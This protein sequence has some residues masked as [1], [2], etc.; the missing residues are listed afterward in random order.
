MLNEKLKTSVGLKIIIIGILIVLLMIPS[1][2]IMT[3]IDDREGYRQEVLSDI[4]SKWGGNQYVAG[5]V[6]I[7]PVEF[8]NENTLGQKFISTKNIFLLSESLEVESNLQPEIRYRGIYE[9]LLYQSGMNLKGKF[10]LDAIEELDL[11]HGKIRYDKAYLEIGISDLKGLTNNLKVNWNG[12]EIPARTGLKEKSSVSKG[13]HFLIPLQK[14]KKEYVYSMN[15]NLN[16]SVQIRFSPTG[17]NTIVKISAPWT[18]PSFCGDFLP[19]QKLIDD[20][21]FEAEWE[22]FN[23]NRNFSHISFGTPNNI[24][25]NFFGVNLFYP[26]DQYQQT[27]RSVKYA[28]LFLSLTFVCFFLIEILSKKQIHPLQYLLVGSGIVLFYLLLLSLTEHM[29]FSIAYLIACISMIALI[30]LYTKSA[31]GE[32]KLT[33]IVSAVLLA[34]YGFLFINLQLQDYALLVGSLGLFITLAGVMFFTRKID[35]F[36]ALNQKE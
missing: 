8:L 17:K 35:W 33:L 19:Q 13:L 16:G 25:D 3:I 9:I 15:M 27:T 26:V 31:L 20:Q 23:L 29:A 18:H 24:E 32:F 14:D 30:A 36:A 1:V 28:F 7:I 6:L 10:N 21:H 11:M 22:I 12:Q 2:W 5:P 34:L 4:T